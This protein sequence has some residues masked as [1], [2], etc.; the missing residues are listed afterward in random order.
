MTTPEASFKVEHLRYELA[1]GHTVTVERVE[2]SY[3]IKYGKHAGEQRTDL[4]WR[5]VCTCEQ[6]VDATGYSFG[7][8]A[9]RTYLQQGK[10]DEFVERHTRVAKGEKGIYACG[11]LPNGKRRRECGMHR[12][13]YIPKV[14]SNYKPSKMSA[15][16]V[17][18]CLG[19]DYPSPEW[20]FFE[21]L[22]LGTGWDYGNTDGIKAD[23]RLDAF[24]MHT[25]PSRGFLRIAFEVKVSRGDFRHEIKHP[26]KRACALAL[27]NQYFFVT[28]MGL[29]KP[30]E[31]PE[32]C[33]LIEIKPTGGRIVRVQA[34]WREAINPPLR[35]V[36]SLARRIDREQAPI[37]GSLDVA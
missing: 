1:E 28:P 3:E 9:D 12:E 15:A 22:R 4:S 16:E 13:P 25:W 19:F 14:P 18:R 32:E 31:I 8:A 20:A 33:G 27:S 2:S 23:Q 6:H 7:D 30:E 36:A 34:P 37:Q 21:E 29:V 17:L 5:A 11:C 10:V 35:F 24:A 26:E